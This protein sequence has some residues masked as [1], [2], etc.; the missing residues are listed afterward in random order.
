[1]ARE[2]ELKEYNIIYATRTDSIIYQTYKFTKEELENLW[3][4]LEEGK[5][6]I[7]TNFGFL[8]LTD[9]RA[10]IEYKEPPKQEEQEQSQMTTG[11]PNG[12]M[13]VMAYL[14]QLEKEAEDAEV[15]GRMFY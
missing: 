13:A 14:K 15:E 7:R 4:A 1:M 12:D 10:V 3:A 6:G 2:R 8:V 9:V 11:I 5:R